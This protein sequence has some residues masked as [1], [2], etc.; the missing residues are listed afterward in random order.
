MF[1]FY[2]I[3]LFPYL[4]TRVSSYNLKP[5]TDYEENFDQCTRVAASVSEQMFNVK[6]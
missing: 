5:V 6:Y 3:C 1:L 4:S 2:S